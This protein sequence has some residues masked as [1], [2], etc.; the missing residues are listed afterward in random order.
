M[1]AAH[2]G[3]VFLSLWCLYNIYDAWDVFNWYDILISG[4]IFG[5]FPV[6]LLF[7]SIR[8]WRLDKSSILKYLDVGGISVAVVT[9]FAMIW[10]LFREASRYFF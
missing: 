8:M 1:R 5:L 6:A 3:I 10:I 2:L 7:L 9:V 4:L